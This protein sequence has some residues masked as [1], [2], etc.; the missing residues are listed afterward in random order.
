MADVATARRSRTLEDIMAV[1][2]NSF[3]L[4]RLAMAIAV[5]FSHSYLFQ[6]GMRTSEP[7]R[8]WTDH[9]LGEHAVQVFFFLSGILIAQSFDR[10]RSL[11]DFAAARILRIFPGLVVCV[12]LTAFLLGPLLS[13]STV[14]A[15]FTDARLPLYLAKTIG[16]VTGSAP[17]PGLFAE[18]AT[19]GLVNMSL[20]TLKYEAICYLGVAALGMA[21][22]FNPRWRTAATAVLAVGVLVVFIGE[23]KPHASYTFLDNARYFAVYFGMGTLAYMLRAH[24]VIRPI[25]LLPLL[26][27]MAV[28]I[29]T[30]FAEVAT[31]LFLGYATVVLAS[32]SWGWL[33]DFTRQHDYSYGVY[34]YAAPLQQAMLLWWPQIDPIVLSFWSLAAVLPFAFASWRLV[35]KPALGLRAGL[36]G[37]VQASG[38]LDRL[39]DRMKAFAPA[40]TAMPQP[41]PRKGAGA[42]PSRKRTFG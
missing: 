22:L 20:W 2:R 41:V 3:G 18:H 8:A 26:A 25:L 42:L 6:T 36:A 12:L 24:L 16:L 27:L 11:L 23:P 10:S 37:W 40:L 38:R 1:D 33:S 5:L 39:A 7:I 17:L 4:I 34:I 30:R 31:A 32:M 9:S 15:Y 35:E 13:T 19:P 14:H 28:A 21:G 29:G